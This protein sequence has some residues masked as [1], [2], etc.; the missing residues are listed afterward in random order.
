MTHGRNNTV[1]VAFFTAI[2]FFAF[3]CVLDADESDWPMFIGNGSRTPPKQGAQLVDDLD[4]MR[5][6]WELD[7]HMG[8][9]KGLYPGTLKTARAMGIEPF[10]G[11]TAS[12][13]VADDTVFCTYYKPDGKV[14]AAVE[15]WRTV[16]DP[17]SLLPPW[18]FSVT[19]DDI[20]LAVDARS[21][22]VKWKAVER[23]KGLNRLGH[24][25][26]HWCVS[27]ASANGRVFSMGT[28]GLLYAYDGKTGKKL[29][30]TLAMPELEAMRREVVDKKKLIWN[31]G[32]GSSLVVAD[33]VVV[34]SRRSL[35]GFDAKTGGQRWYLKGHIES[36]FGT[37][38]IW[39]HKGREYLL[40]NTGAGELRLI[41]PQDG[42]V[43][44]TVDG[45]GPLLGTL[46]VTGDV[47]IVNVGGKQ[48]QG[49]SQAGLFGAYRLALEGPKKLWTLRDEPRYRHEWH[50]DAGP[51]KK[52]A[53]QDGRAYIALYHPKGDDGQRPPCS[54]I[55]VD[56]DTGKI[57]SEQECGRGSQPYTFENRILLFHDRHHSDPVTA[58]FWTADITPRKLTGD[59]AFPHVAITAYEVPIQWPYVDG[60]LYC[61]TLKGLICYD[62]RIPPAAANA[63]ELHLQIPAT[64]T[65]RRES[66]NVLLYEYEGRFTHGGY[67]DAPM[68]HAVAVSAA[69]WD[70]KQL[71]GTLHVDLE[72]NHRLEAYMVDATLAD[73][74]LE[75]TVST[76]VA[77]LSKPLPVSGRVTAAEHQP[78]WM[79]DCTHVLWLEEAVCNADRSRQPMFLFVTAADGRLVRVEGFATRTT[80]ARPMVDARELQVAGNRLTGRIVVRFRP[81]AWSAPLAKSGQSAAAE[82]YFDCRL[83]K[84]GEAGSFTGTYGV[85]W[86]QATRL[87]GKIE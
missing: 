5:V 43:L 76:T 79:P 41:D 11:G 21:G 22:K 56:I 23:G 72:G 78:A 2:L 12:P 37:P 48:G 71:G 77:G 3:V 58:S 47:V 85:A 82:Y 86:S 18:F 28:A 55:V 38:T 52:V 70:G 44:W 19:A 6:A 73:A 59:V 40:A 46:S 14:R 84:T 10:Y 75:G 66:M 67:R 68:L 7:H 9:G 65:G 1:L 87:Q 31:T 34:V 53:I 49:K 69:R 16:D 51:S 32:E 60:L 20:V 35:T 50:L 29:W 33:G 13:I 15:A 45:L 63:R 25:R 83:V 36:P 26:S 39:R 4:S 61:R 62:L 42:R 74:V 24:K 57:L 64:L 8:V 27:P 30:E 80:Q 54:L 81:D 17:K